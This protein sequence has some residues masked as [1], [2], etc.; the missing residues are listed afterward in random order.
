[1]IAGLNFSLPLLLSLAQCA[2][3]SFAS[4]SHDRPELGAARSAPS[5]PHRPIFIEAEPARA[6]DPPR[7][8][9]APP[10]VPAPPTPPDVIRL[11]P[12]LVVEPR[13][14]AGAQWIGVRLSP[15]PA[16]LAAHIGEEG[17]MI[18][19]IV[20]DGPADR[21]GLQ[22]YDV[23]LSFDGQKLATGDDL[24]KAVQ[25][26]RAGAP[27]EIVVVRG[28]AQKKLEITP[29]ARPREDD[30]EY[31]YEDDQDLVDQDFRVR[32]RW[33]RPGP[34]GWIFEDLGPM[35]ELPDA[36]KE[37]QHYT[38]PDWLKQFLPEDIDVHVEVDPDDWSDADEPGE[39]RVEIRIQRDDD[40]KTMSIRRTEDGKIHV[41]R[42]EPGG[43]S[44]SAVYENEEELRGA[45]P[46]AWEL[47]SE[48]VRRHGHGNWHVVR[49]ELDRLG[50]LRHEFQAEVEH[51]LQSALERAREAYDQA[52]KA[53]EAARELHVEIK[54]RSD[55]DGAA[56]GRSE[57]RRESL[58]LEIGD[59][60][61]ITVT[62]D[63]GD[64][65][66]RHEF[67]NA[68]ELRKEK[69]ELYERLRGV[70]E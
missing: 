55:Q 62:V 11:R 4:G 52:Q 3:V 47:Y 15:I 70:L 63:D 34:G 23:L 50:S 9:P 30:W 1:M 7:R 58:S 5:A 49:P 20:R 28:G 29:I 24:V 40:G 44:Q 10:A 39:V 51:K 46:Q 69:P 60:G 16:P 35:R 27:V 57:S 18:G 56:A 41:E 12:E 2:T 53:A 6:P 59:D 22:R 37:F 26:A 54:R 32:G 33:L 45:D 8:G 13:N 25:A 38:D 19:N 42:S 67:R 65:P 43:K 48:N 31:K 36:L 64:G 14:N 17:L 61:H 21:A 68:E 66:Q